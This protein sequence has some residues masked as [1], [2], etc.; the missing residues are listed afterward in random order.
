MMQFIYHYGSRIAN[1]S[2]NLITPPTLS[3]SD[4]C[5]LV[6][7]VSDVLQGCHSER[8]SLTRTESTPSTELALPG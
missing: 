7:S 5:S 2:D 3:P 6:H 8:S 4:G 1:N